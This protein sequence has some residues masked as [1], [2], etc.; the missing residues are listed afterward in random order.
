[1]ATSPST[2]KRL[3]SRLVLLT[4]AWS[5][6]QSDVYSL[7]LESEIAV[8]IEPD[9][10]V[11]TSLLGGRRGIPLDVQETVIGSDA[12]GINAIVVTSRRLLGFSS[13]TL[14]WSETD[15]D[16]D[17]K[18]LERRILPTFSLVRTDKRLYGFRAANGIWFKEAL[19]VREKVYRLHS[20][21]YGSVAVTNE[22]LVGFGP[23]LGE[24]SSRP[25][26]VHERITQ[27]NNESGVIIITTN[28]R[29]LVFGSR[30]SG[31]DEFE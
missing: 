1:M 10:A 18:V 5:S 20:N 30:M 22:R 15:R 9:Q 21:D 26:G 11:A 4:L 3:A 23:L 17:E 8:S 31:W 27:V 12:K 13:R 16:L 2:I 19:G 7:G 25:L 6:C 29:T 24:F 14:T 28:Q